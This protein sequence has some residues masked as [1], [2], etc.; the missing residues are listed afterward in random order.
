MRGRESRTH[1]RVEANAEE[2][3]RL[4]LTSK[5]LLSTKLIFRPNIVEKMNRRC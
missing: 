5:I 4:K 3:Y 1:L 2:E